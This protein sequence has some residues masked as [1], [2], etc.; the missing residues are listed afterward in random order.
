MVLS[1]SLSKTVHGSEAQEAVTSL[2]RRPAFGANSDND[3]WV[4][5]QLSMWT[6]VAL[7]TNPKA[8]KVGLLVRPG[9]LRVGVLSLFR[10]NKHLT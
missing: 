10:K 2:N 1:W 4:F 7:G 9:H 6:Q 5:N 3:G 8:N